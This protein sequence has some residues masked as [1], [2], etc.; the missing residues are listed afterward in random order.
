MGNK[1]PKELLDMETVVRV[2]IKRDNGETRLA[3]VSNVIMSK[4]VIRDL[5]ES[6]A[7]E[8]GK[9]KDTRIHIDLNMDQV[10]RM[11][12]LSGFDL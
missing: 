1:T 9:L 5:L 6:I 12:A 7:T 8:E 2:S 10:K 4:V 11:A 3:S